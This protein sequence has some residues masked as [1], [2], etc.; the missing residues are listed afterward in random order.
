[1]IEQWNVEISEDAAAGENFKT[2]LKSIKNHNIINA[3]F[4]FEYYKNLRK[5]FEE[6]VTEKRVFQYKDKLEA[7]K[8]LQQR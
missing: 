6:L 1:M 7:R 3:K 5:E 2:E 4:S 8:T